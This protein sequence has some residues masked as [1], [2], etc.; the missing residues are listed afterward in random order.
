MVIGHFPWLQ[1]SRFGCSVSGSLSCDLPL[2]GHWQDV[3]VPTDGSAVFEVFDVG[4][5][6]GECVFKFTNAYAVTN[7]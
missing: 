3:K 1:R 6:Y 4:R 2:K 7:C 5:V